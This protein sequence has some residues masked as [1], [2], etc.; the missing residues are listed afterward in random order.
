MDLL[1]HV[2]LHKTGT[3]AVQMAL[4]Q[5]D[6][7]LR[8][9]GILYPRSGLFSC[10][11]ALIPGSLLPTHPFLDQCDRSLDPG[12]YTSLLRAELELI[13]PR[14]VIMSSEVFTEVIW[15]DACAELIASI[16]RSFTR[17]TLLLSLRN[18]AAQAL[19]SLKH[20][21]REGF[22]HAC[23]DPVSTYHDSSA[24]SVHCREFWKTLPYP[25]IE[26]HLED[27]GSSLLDHYFGETIGDVSSSA[28]QA[29]LDEN[30]H[31]EALPRLANSDPLQ[32]VVY[33]ALFLLGNTHGLSGSQ[34]GSALTLTQSAIAR[35]P[36][37]SAP[38]MRLTSSQLISYLEIVHDSCDVKAAEGRDV[39]MPLKIE[40]LQR[41]GLSPLEVGALLT[42]VD[43]FKRFLATQG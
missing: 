2:G 1:L 32:P 29:L 39:P 12:H 4:S 23:L 21:V 36:L 3:T 20:M 37:L 10:Q 33:L 8:H 15:H 41:A 5:K 30:L 6:A 7:M 42:L 40:A 24:Y 35:E 11:H 26:R 34:V 28:R 14:L 19:S 31:D 9:H 18:P 38:R 17:T 22:D 25:V 43:H 27:S 13:K 16:A